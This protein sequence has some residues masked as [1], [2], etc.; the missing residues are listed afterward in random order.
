MDM[1][2]CIYA[3]VSVCMYTCVCACVCVRVCAHMDLRR[4]G[5][6]RKAQLTS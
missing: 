5:R 3:Y 4:S 1:C 2:V 6:T